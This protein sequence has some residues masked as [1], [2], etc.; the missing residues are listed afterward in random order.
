MKYITYIL[1]ALLL[2][3]CETPFFSSPEKYET[4]FENKDGL[5]S[6]SYEEV[7]DYYKQLSQD[8]ASISFK[9]MGQ[10]DNG[11]PLHLVIYS[12][13]AE[14]NFNKYH[15]ERTIIFINNAVHGNEPDG[16]DATML[17]FRNLAQNEI[18]LSGNVMVVTIPA[19][20]IGGMQENRKESAAHYNLDN[21]FV[22]ADVENTLS[23]AKIFQEVQPDIFIDNQVSRKEEY[24]YTL[25]YSFSNKQ[26]LGAF[27]GGYIENV[28]TPRL[29]DTLLN[30]S[31]IFKKDTL[32]KPFRRLIVDETIGRANNAIGYA[33]LWNCI[34]VRL[35]THIFQSY[36]QRV[37]ANY[38]TMKTIIEVADADNQYIKQLKIKQ[39]QTDAKE[40]SPEYYIIPK[41]WQQ[42]IARLNAHNIEMK[43][44]TKDTLMNVNYYQ[45]EDFK[46][47]THPFEGHYLHYD[48]QVSNHKEKM[49]FYKGDYVVPTS[50]FAKRYLLETLEPTAT[51]S[52]F[53][54]NFFDSIFRE[55]VQEENKIIYPIYRKE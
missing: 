12:P 44:L 8:F 50:Q 27:L 16:V 46:T 25:S 35:N 36:K 47:I 42:V 33:S 6:S 24:Q 52:F 38:E 54:W 40:V 28:L 48:T 3:S 31:D 37:E 5:K 4:P 26:K 7:I 39:A 49:Q 2:A 18:K 21:D 9:T 45:I 43:E 15:K 1:S 23:F 13:D 30:R 32:Q 34:G 17:L 29:A 10:T 11:V 53:N 20:N 51:D 55:G 41:A 14:F 19:Y 22:K